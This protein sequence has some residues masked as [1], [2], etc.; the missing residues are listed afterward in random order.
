MSEPV[1]I[2]PLR[3]VVEQAGQEIQLTVE[4]DDAVTMLD[5]SGPV[6]V[7]A[8]ISTMLGVSGTS[9]IKH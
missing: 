6:E 7:I 1:F 5:C 3:I 9:E 2:K 8:R 4:R